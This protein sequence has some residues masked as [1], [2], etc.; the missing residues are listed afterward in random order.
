MQTTLEAFAAAGR[1]VVSFD[2]ELREIVGRSL[3]VSVSAVALAAAVGLPF[4]AW[5]AVARF[6]G[7]RAAV[8]LLDALIGVPPVVVGLFVYLLFTS[9]GPLG[10][11]GWLHSVKAMVVAQV[12]VVF[13]MVATFTRQAVE[14]LWDEYADQLRSLGVTPRQAIPTLLYDARPQLV[15]ILLAGFGRAIGEVGAVF[16]V[17]GN[18]AHATRVMTTAI[19]LETSKGDLELALGLGLVL[20][21]IAIVVHLAAHLLRRRE[22]AA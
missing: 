12:L 15:T 13:P 8:A 20:I 21:A 3:A 19:A 14:A 11:W 2:A 10:S 4:G 1:L 18:I 7:R 16:I 9:Y 22:R 5:L 6:R 17:G